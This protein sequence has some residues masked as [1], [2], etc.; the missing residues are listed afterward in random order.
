M[1]AQPA[2][3]IPYFIA[4]GCFTWKPHRLYQV[5]VQDQEL[6]FIYLGGTMGVSFNGSSDSF[7]YQVIPMPLEDLL[8][9]HPNHFSAHRD[10]LTMA[11]LEPLGFWKRL[12]YTKERQ[13]GLFRFCNAQMGRYTLEIPT[14]NEMHKAMELLP[15]ALGERLS[16]HL[17]WDE[18][19][20]RYL[21]KKQ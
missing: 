7:I 6:T 18:T 5:Y 14:T 3:E 19:R 17:T 4:I 2:S 1:T 21:R 9:L 11:S 15:G 12:L 8:P 10:S 13:A 20:G 16:I